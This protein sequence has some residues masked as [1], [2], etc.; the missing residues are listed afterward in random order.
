VLGFTLL[1]I[2]CIDQSD[3]ELDG[4]SL[5]P[6]LALPL[7]NGNLT[8]SD[9]LRSKDSAHF[10]SYPDGLMYV[11]YEDQLISKDIRDLFSIPNLV[12]DKSFVMPGMTVPPHTK[13]IRSDS[14]ITTVGFQMSPEKLSE[15]F[16]KEGKFSFSTSLNPASSQLDYEVAV[17]LPG[18]ISPTNQPLS[19][20]I[21]GAGTIDLKN[22]KI[23]LTDNK[24]DLKLVLIFR[25]NPT[26][27]TIPPA[28]SVNVQLNFGD[29]GFIH[30]KGFL[31]DQTT[32]LDA[33]SMNL[34]AFSGELFKTADLS[35]AQPK[36]TFTVFNGNGMPCT[37]TFIKLEARKPGSDPMSIV[38]NPANP[39]SLNYP[40]VIGE[41]KETSF[42]VVNVKDL[43][44]Y[45][46]T[47]IYYQTDAR[48]NPGLT[49]GNNFLLDSSRLKVKLNVD[50]PLWGS[51][52][53]IVMKDTLDVDFENVKSSEV[54]KASLKLKL[55]NQFP[56][57]GNIQF[58]LTDAAY[59]VIGTLLL[60]EQTHVIKGSTV[61]SDGELQAA[62][63][64]LETIELDQAKIEN[65]F[66]AEHIIITAGL[67]TSRNS[68]GAATD[69][70]F[71]K[72]YFLS[73]EAGILATLKLNVE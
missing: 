6:T 49:S 2:S 57:D 24:F 38:L 39:V 60:P 23:K 4:V 44:E 29:F 52:S 63:A 17:S 71:M 61:D 28:T 45:A 10:K 20:T 34:G 43:M 31:G 58:V 33:Q 66:D 46:P 30:L 70:K 9:M 15:M 19:T 18:F 41:T 5:N 69:V 55:I 37:A 12:V 42:G 8:I 13:D 50:V 22:Y 26:S 62:G 65:L 32:S 51:A 21:R 72:D 73:I 35:L 3:Y 54:S 27:T 40:Q 59:N 36:V 67:Q 64:Y 7:A 14:I 16:L 53:G 56:L 11:A 68:A 1:C 25:K 48:I 47:E